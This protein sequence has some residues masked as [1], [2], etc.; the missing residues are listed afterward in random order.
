MMTPKQA[1]EN[2]IEQAPAVLKKDK[3]HAPI[4]F[5]FGEKESAVVLLRFPKPELKHKV[6]M[7]TGAKV[8]HLRPNCIAFVSEAW[9]SRTIP[10]EGKRV[11]EMPDKQECLIVIA[12]NKEGETESVAIPFSK[13]GNEIFLGQTEWAPEAESPLLESFWKGVR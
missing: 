13:V 1:I 12:Q 7:A 6:M 10:P 11:A 8:A 9:M 3:F 5:V 2:I 4:L